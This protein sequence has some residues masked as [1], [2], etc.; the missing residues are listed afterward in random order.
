MPRRDLTLADNIALLEQIKN[1][2]PN[3]SHSQLVE[4]TGVPK[5]IIGCIIQW[6]KKLHLLQLDEVCQ[7][8]NIEKQVRGVS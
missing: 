3:I 5:S 1:Q 6:Q 7:W 2:P 8:S 4:T